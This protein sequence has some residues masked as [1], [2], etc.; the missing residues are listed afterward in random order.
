MLFRPSRSAL[1]SVAMAL[2]ASMSSTVMTRRKAWVASCS[3]NA[4]AKRS[5]PARNTKLLEHTK[6][7]LWELVKLLLLTTQSKMAKRLMM[8]SI[9]LAKKDR[10]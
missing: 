9:S 10:S 2:I 6:K 7:E 3:R 1:A 4:P 5:S 8:L